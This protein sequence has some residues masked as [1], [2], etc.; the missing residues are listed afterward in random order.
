LV[1]SAP[2]IVVSVVT[3]AWAAAEAASAVARTVLRRN[4]VESFTLGLL[5]LRLENTSN[6]LKEL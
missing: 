3:T 2:R 6:R 4:N 5:E 1:K